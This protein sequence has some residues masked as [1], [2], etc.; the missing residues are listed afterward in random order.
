M[1]YDENTLMQAA[2][3]SQMR[4]QQNQ[5]LQQEYYN[6][7]QVPQ[8]PQ[9][10][11]KPISRSV[12]SS[13]EKR[14]YANQLAQVSELN[15]LSVPNSF[16]TTPI[17]QSESPSADTKPS[18]LRGISFLD[19]LFEVPAEAHDPLAPDGTLRDDDGENTDAYD[20]L[21]ADVSAWLE[22]NGNLVEGTEWLDQVVLN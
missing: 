6:P 12:P 11:A 19:E 3:L 10:A 7:Q 21:E 15:M 5:Q 20:A 16:S 14:R 17:K 8:S 4:Q 1:V 13:P 18:H 2:L 9:R 22:G